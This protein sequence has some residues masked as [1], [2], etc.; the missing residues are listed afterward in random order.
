MNRRVYH[1]GRRVQESQ[2]SRLVLD[3]S[4]M[5]YKKKVFWLDEG[6]VLPLDTTDQTEMEY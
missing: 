6:K 4:I 2:R 5:V 3:G 1:E